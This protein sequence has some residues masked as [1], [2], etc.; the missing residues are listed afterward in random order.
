MAKGKR[1][2]PKERMSTESRWYIGV[3]REDPCAYCGGPGGT[4]DHIVPKFSAGENQWSN[5]TSACFGCNNRK[6][7]RPLLAYLLTT[8]TGP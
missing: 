7:A 6:K 5:F 3:L 1:R 2:Q 8:A 4:I